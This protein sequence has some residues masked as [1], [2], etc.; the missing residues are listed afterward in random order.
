M[1]L[2]W[3]ITC[4][5]KGSA[6]GPA[7]VLGCIRVGCLWSPLLRIPRP[8]TCTSVPAFSQG[9]TSHAPVLCSGA[10]AFFLLFKGSP[11]LSPLHR[12]LVSHI[13]QP[14][15]HDLTGLARHPAW[16]GTPVTWGSW[17]SPTVAWA[18]SD[19]IPSTPSSNRPAVFH[20]YVCPCSHITRMPPPG[21]GRRW[22]IPPKPVPI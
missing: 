3:P 1:S 21:R 7:S 2:P 5:P 12:W 20:C 15:N 19:S 13:P 8:L 9:P 22:H 4:C 18:L 10:S 6:V 17:P 11:H 14:L 16:P